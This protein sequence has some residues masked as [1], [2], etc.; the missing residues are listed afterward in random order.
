MNWQ[1]TTDLY[2]HQRAAVTKLLP[3]RVGA[4]FMEMGTGKTRAAIELARIR[5]EKIEHVLWYCPVTLKETVRF[6]IQKHTSC[7]D[8]DI[9]VFDE[10]TRPGKLP[11]AFWYVIGI[12]S[13][14]ASDRVV[15]A[16]NELTTNKTFVIVDES[17][18]IKGHAARRTQRITA[19]SERAKYRTVLTG[20][21]ISQGVIDLY[22][23][24]RF[25]SPKILGYRSFYSFA[26]N[27]LEYS[28]K[29]PGLI[30]A[31]HHTGYLAARM[32][33]YVYQVTKAECLDLPAKVV[34]SRRF[35]MTREQREA[36]EQAKEELLL[37]V[38]DE[39]IDSYTIF[40]LFTALQQIV[41]G[42]WKRDG[43]LIEFP[44]IRLDI[45]NGVINDI[46]S[47]AKVI[48][49]CKYLYS[50]RA[51]VERLRSRFGDDSVAEYHGGLTERERH[52]QVT[53]FKSEARFFLATQATGGHGLTLNEAH[54]VIF[55]ENEFK[56]ASRIQAE[57]RCHRIGQSE[58][59]TYVDI[60]CNA[61]I[62][63][64]IMDALATKGDTVQDFKRK[65]DEVKEGRRDAMEKLVR[66]L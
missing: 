48:I 21:P 63:Q 30:V 45:L 49:W 7:T 55:Y 5:R 3:S 1:T 6:E 9:H 15:L 13:M 64:R 53:R 20:T 44:H 39:D 32:Q 27:H 35:G 19:L 31:A 23:Q 47:D 41:S 54:Y 36:Y 38:P 52:A 51:I 37:S 17:S 11:A 66:S 43:R 42:Y 14:S 65:I 16:A 4:L 50:L 56:Y 8:A 34:D 57:D 46:P 61:G 60:V 12:E 58:R 18:Y 26:R 40:R 10:R 59:V 2:S 33:P 29:Y 25:L 24:M 22:A 62:D 28:E